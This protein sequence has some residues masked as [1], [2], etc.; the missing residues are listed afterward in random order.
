MANVEQAIQF[1][2]ETRSRLDAEFEQL[3]Q[4]D[5]L[6]ITPIADVAPGVV[7][8]LDFPVNA[9][10]GDSVRVIAINGGGVD[11]LRDH[12]LDEVGIAERERLPV[13]ENIAPIALVGEQALAEFVFQSDRELVPWATRVTMTPAECDRQILK[14]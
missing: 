3:Q 5:D 2:R 4:V 10:L 8:F 9:F 13:L 12:V 1:S 14:R 7:G 6:V 11:E